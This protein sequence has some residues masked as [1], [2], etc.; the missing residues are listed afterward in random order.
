MAQSRKGKLITY[1]NNNT[2]ELPREKQHQI[3]GAITEIDNIIEILNSCRPNEIHE[4]N[5]P[6]ELF[7]FRPI[8]GK[9]LLNDVKK[10]IKEMF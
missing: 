9:G 5:N 6:D 8:H 3:Y 10:F 1:L 7:L 2:D 4:E